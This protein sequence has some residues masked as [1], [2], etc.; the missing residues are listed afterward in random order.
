MIVQIVNE[1]DEIIGAKQYGE[2]NHPGDIY[3]VSALW[4][5]NSKNQ[6]L[7]AQRSLTE[8]SDPGKWGPAV[9]GTIGEGE[10]YD[11]NIYKEAAEEIGLIGVEFTKSVK[12]YSSGLRR[13]FTQWYRA[14]IDRD[15][16]EFTRQ[17]EE[18]NALAWI[19]T[20]QLKMEL[21]ARPD[22]YTPTL[23]KL[24]EELGL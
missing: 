8:D 24:V 11:E 6:S 2:V 16:A 10:S 7:I 15:I 21:Q 14:Q 12:T 23:P 9:A 13:Y 19:D 20:E 22:K 1:N 3:R 4:I 17:V 5:T 18:V